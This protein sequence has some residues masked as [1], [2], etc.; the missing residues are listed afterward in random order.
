MWVNPGL[1]KIKKEVN[2]FL[3]YL[4]SSYSSSCPLRHTGSTEI[5]SE[6][7]SKYEHSYTSDEIK[8]FCK[9]VRKTCFRNGGLSCTL[10]K[11]RVIYINTNSGD[12]DDEIIHELSHIMSVTYDHTSEFER[13]YKFLKNKYKEYRKE[14][15]IILSIL[16]K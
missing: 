6:K 13:N 5:V 14:K 4:S 2:D 1:F 15:K 8:N 12:I 7:S 16:H 9:K 3:E 10:D 11:G